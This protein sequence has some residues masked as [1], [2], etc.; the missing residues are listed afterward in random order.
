M[1]GGWGAATVPLLVVAGAVFGPPGAA[2]LV[3]G[4]RELA[5]SVGADLLEVRLRPR[6]GDGLGV[7][8]ATTLPD[9]RLG[10]GRLVDHL[11]GAVG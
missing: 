4:V 2:P 3:D 10:G 5:R 9:L 11:A 6:G 1:P 7:V 8:G